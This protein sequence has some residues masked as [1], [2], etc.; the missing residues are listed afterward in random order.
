MTRLR[1][2]DLANAQL[3]T[4][5]RHG[6]Q[7]VA[8]VDVDKQYVVGDLGRLQVYCIARGITFKREWSLVEWPVGNGHHEGA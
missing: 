2:S 4:V 7:L 6:G 5:G 3:V 8:T 1:P